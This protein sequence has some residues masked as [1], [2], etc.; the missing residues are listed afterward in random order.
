[1]QKKENKRKNFISRKEGFRCEKC[2]ENNESLGAGTRNH[3]KVCLWSKHVDSVVV[4][5]RLSECGGM[6]KPVEVRRKGE[7]WRVRQVCVKCGKEW[8]NKVSGDD[9]FEEVIKIADEYAKNEIRGEV[10]EGFGKD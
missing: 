10:G 3:C 9:N 6:M 5:D 8:W 4:G 7:G 2:G 1:M